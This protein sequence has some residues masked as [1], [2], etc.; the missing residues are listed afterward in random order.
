M[1]RI[2]SRVLIIL[3]LT[4]TAVVAWICLN[5]RDGPGEVGFIVWGLVSFL[6]LGIAWAVRID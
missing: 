5:A 1:T 4:F 6:L 2:I 3:W